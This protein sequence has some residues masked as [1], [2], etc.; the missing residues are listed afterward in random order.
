MPAWGTLRRLMGLGLLIGCAACAMA[1]PEIPGAQ[2]A[3]PAGGEITGYTTTTTLI[4]QRP[5]AFNSLNRPDG[6]ELVRDYENSSET[7]EVTGTWND[8]AQTLTATV[9]VGLKVANIV[10][11]VDGA[12][13]AEAE[14]PIQAGRNALREV[15]CP[16]T[17]PVEHACY[18]LQVLH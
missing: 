9:T 2:P 12:M 4:Y 1:T 10:Y 16:Q 7:E 18:L 13:P 15:V 5:P 17:V 8:D 6:F 3:A 11:V 14:T